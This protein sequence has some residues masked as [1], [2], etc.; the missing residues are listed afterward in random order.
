MNP[1]I[2]TPLTTADVLALYRQAIQVNPA[3][4]SGAPKPHQFRETMDGPWCA[5][6]KEMHGQKGGL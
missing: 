5:I 3:R 1:T 6:C 4:E 2:T